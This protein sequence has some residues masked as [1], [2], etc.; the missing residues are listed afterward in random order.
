MNE[1]FLGSSS[2]LVWLAA[3]TAGPP[4]SPSADRLRAPIAVQP[5]ASLGAA[6]L[7]GLAAID[8][9][10]AWV[11]GGK[12]T[13]ARTLDG[14]ATWQPVAPPGCEACDFRDVQAF[15]RDTAVVM[16]AGTP[17]RLFRTTDGGTSWQT[18]LHDERPGAFF[19]AFAFDG[20]RGVLFG[21]PLDGA[22]S[23]WATVDAGVTWT[24]IDRRWLPA[25][26]PGEAAFAASGTCVAVVDG[27]FV[28]ATGGGERARLLVGGPEGPWVVR[29]LPLA[30]GTSSSGAFGVA[31]HGARIVVLGGDY[32]APRVSQGT[33]ALSADGGTTWRAAPGGA[34]GFRSAAVWLDE[35]TVFAIG[36]HG[37][38]LSDDGGGS[39]RVLDIGG[40]HAV[41][42]GQD[43][44]LWCCGDRGCVARLH[45]AR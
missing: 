2:W 14:G 11:G 33:A 44:A 15:D 20:P 7:R 10:V 22:F 13:L 26:L 1:R 37:A 18:V 43:G 12:G 16:V 35:R 32:R 29:D 27:S 42:R 5:C 40:G 38:S 19:D 45:F 6:T 9:E 4:A 3:C 36:S 28:V 41:A 25:P 24:A 23:L 31:A 39:W 34:G 17:A 8:G 21:D 30:A